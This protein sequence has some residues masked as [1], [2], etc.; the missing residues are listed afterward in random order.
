MQAEG[1]GTGPA[2]AP[3]RFHGPVDCLVKTLRFEGV[4]ALYAGMSIPLLGTVFETA[5][6]FTANGLFRRAL[7]SSGRLAEG[8]ALPLS[9][10]LASGAASGSVVAL[11]LTPA[12]LI[13]CRLQV[14]TAKGRRS[15]VQTTH[16]G[17]IA[18]TPPAGASD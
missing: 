11:V 6:M 16:L 14:G 2:G 15:T 9:M 1:P 10:V 7:V 12:E 17:C 18:N 8:E 13:K 3:P 5:I 4:R